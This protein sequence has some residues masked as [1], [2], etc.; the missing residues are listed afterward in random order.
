M[1]AYI[2]LET[3]E[4]AM[5]SPARYKAALI[6]AWFAAINLRNR[7]TWYQDITGAELARLTGLG[8][9]TLSDTFGQNFIDH[10][11][12]TWQAMPVVLK[13]GEHCLHRIRDQRPA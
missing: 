11:V 8:R 12:E 6:D 3:L 4:F 10:C 13:S 9:A 7:N 1:A 2:K 5:A